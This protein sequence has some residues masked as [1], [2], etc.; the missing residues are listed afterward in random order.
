M[1]ESVGGSLAREEG[2]IVMYDFAGFNV[3][4]YCASVVAEKGDG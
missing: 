4:V 1:P 2:G 3:E